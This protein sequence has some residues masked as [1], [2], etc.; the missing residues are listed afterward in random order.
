M[1]HED[2]YVELSGECVKKKR[3]DETILVNVN[4]LYEMMSLAMR[5]IE[6]ESTRKKIVEVQYTAISKARNQD[7]MFVPMSIEEVMTSFGSKIEGMPRNTFIEMKKV[8]SA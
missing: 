2:E 8:M 4:R 7:E 1:R 3:N 6:N 5:S